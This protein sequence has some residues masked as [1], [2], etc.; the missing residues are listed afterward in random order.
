MFGMSLGIFSDPQGFEHSV[1]VL[2][3]KFIQAVLCKRHFAFS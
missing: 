3:I 1:Y 2:C